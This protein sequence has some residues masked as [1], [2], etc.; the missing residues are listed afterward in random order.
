MPCRDRFVCLGRTSLPKDTTFADVERHDQH[1][2]DHRQIQIDL[3]NRLAD[4]HLAMSRRHLSWSAPSCWPRLSKAS[5]KNAFFRDGWTGRSRVPRIRL[6][7]IP[8]HE[9]DISTFRC[10]LSQRV[11]NRDAQIYL[12]SVLP[13]QPIS[14]TTALRQNSSL[15]DLTIF[16]R[17]RCAPCLR[18]SSREPNQGMTGAQYRF[19]KERTMDVRV[20]SAPSHECQAGHRR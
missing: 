20:G 19:R 9:C 6:I 16:M 14:A 4:A 11:W 10:M 2:I 18:L 5:P 15:A 17:F 3:V 13:Q 1:F 12:F 7:R 8:L